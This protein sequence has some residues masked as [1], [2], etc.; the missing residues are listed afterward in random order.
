MTLGT[1]YKLRGTI[2]NIC[3]FFMW[4]LPF[5]LQY[6]SIAQRQALLSDQTAGDS[7]AVAVWP[8]QS[9]AADRVW[10][11]VFGVPAVSTTVTAAVDG[12]SH[13]HGAA[14]GHSHGGPEE[15]HSMIGLALV[16]GFVLMLLVDQFTHRHS[17]EQVT[18]KS[19]RTDHRWEP[20]NRSPVRAGI[21]V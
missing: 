5:E 11:R 4:N 1:R 18:G 21:I 14:G 12:H 19:R 7:P 10:R 6:F 3:S 8:C 13:S 20:A 2:S 15:L 16:A 17:G 9:C